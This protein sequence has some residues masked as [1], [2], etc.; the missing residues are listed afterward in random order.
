MIR[1]LL[2]KVVI[3]FQN[4]K[5]RFGGFSKDILFSQS[6]KFNQFILELN[7]QYNSN[8]R[9]DLNIHTQLGQDEEE[10][11]ARNVLTMKNK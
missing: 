9:R 4:W 1:K 7:E 10:L 3:I 2:K 8:P 6:L 11:M 5:R